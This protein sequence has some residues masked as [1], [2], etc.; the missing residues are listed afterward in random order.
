MVMTQNRIVLLNQSRSP[1]EHRI[2]DICIL[3]LQWFWWLVTYMTYIKRIT[4]SIDDRHC[5][6]ETTHR[7]NKLWQFIANIMI[8]IKNIYYTNIIW[9]RYSMIYILWHF[10]MRMKWGRNHWD[11]VIYTFF[12]IINDTESNVV[13]TTAIQI[14][15]YGYILRHLSI[16]LEKG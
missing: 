16:H 12:F 11:T 9:C 1:W 5:R 13:I 15:L 3:H 8:Y 6:G 14:K 4:T 10:S 2:T 7:Q